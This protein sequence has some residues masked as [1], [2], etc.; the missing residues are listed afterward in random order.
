MENN[1]FIIVLV[2]ALVAEAIAAFYLVKNRK[3]LQLISQTV[4]SHIANVRNGF[5]EIKGRVVAIEPPLITPLSKKACV[6][7]D[8]LVEVKRSNG[9]SSYWAKY[10]KDIHY[11]RFGIDDGSGTAVI[12]P[13]NA[14]MK[15]VVD[16]KERSGLFNKADEEQKEVL[17]HYGKKSK[18]LIFEKT[19]RYREIFLEEGDEVI[20]L[21]EVN[22]RDDFRPVF[23]KLNQ[24][25]FVSDKP[26]NELVSSY[27]NKVY[28]SVAAMIVAALALVIFS[29]NVL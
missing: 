12:E 27:R 3:I 2:L 7:Y 24:P 17:N 6:Y 5:Y 28:L 16:R 21:G 1:Q 14:A 18:G 4:T 20:V 8:F 10:I 25:M 29:T 13:Q 15:L 22:S 26:E 23:K 9:K 11:Q 19:L